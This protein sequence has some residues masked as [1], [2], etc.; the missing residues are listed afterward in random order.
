MPTQTISNF[1]HRLNF[2]PVSILFWTLQIAKLGTI[3]TAE[4]RINLY[5]YNVYSTLLKKY[6]FVRGFF[7]TIFAYIK[8]DIIEC[9][10]WNSLQNWA[11][12]ISWICILTLDYSGFFLILKSFHQRGFVIAE[13][14]ILLTK[15]LFG[16]WAIHYNGW[17]VITGTNV[18][19]DFF[20]NA[21][22]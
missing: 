9:K 16:T 8:N 19:F 6:M 10:E 11:V 15:A 12:F 2:I 20:T 5:L 18:F 13:E 22:T 21:K 17:T 3:G 1:C 4:E 14:G 7:F